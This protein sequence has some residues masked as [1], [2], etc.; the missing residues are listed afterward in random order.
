[1]GS[2]RAYAAYGSYFLLA[3]TALVL[4]VLPP[5]IQQESAGE[6]GAVRG[7]VCDE[8]AVKV[9]VCSVFWVELLMLFT[10]SCFDSSTPYT[11]D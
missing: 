7:G 9:R 8:F 11:R 5:S 3:A 6:C 1:M 10:D 4:S 2:A